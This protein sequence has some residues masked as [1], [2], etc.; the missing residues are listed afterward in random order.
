MDYPVPGVQIVGR[1][2]KIQEEKKN[3][4]RLKGERER[5]STFPYRA[6]SALK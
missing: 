4:G 2:R 1:G 3:E 5:L 6:L